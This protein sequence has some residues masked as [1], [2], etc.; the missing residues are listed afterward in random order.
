MKGASALNVL[1]PSIT[2][3]FAMN[4][5]RICF[6]VAM[7]TFKYCTSNCLMNDCNVATAVV[8]FSIMKKMWCINVRNLQKDAIWICVKFVSVGSC[9]W[10][11]AALMHLLF[12][13][14]AFPPRL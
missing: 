3:T 11:A 12:E 10:C 5:M 13:Q 8:I 6:I 2:L 1:H 7:V 9:I 4:V 14:K